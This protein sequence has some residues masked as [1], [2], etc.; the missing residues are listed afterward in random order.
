MAGQGTQ[1]VFWVIWW[2]V[3]VLWCTV[4]SGWCRS[5]EVDE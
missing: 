2:M 5:S 4:D 3:V 1:A